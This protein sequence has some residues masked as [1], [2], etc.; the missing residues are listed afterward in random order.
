MNIVLAIAAVAVSVFSAISFYKAG[1][2]KAKATKEIL[3]G[4][5]MGW[6][7]K[8]PMGVVRVIAWLEILGAIGVV[9]A[10]IGAYLTGLVWSQWVGVAAG[11]GLALTMAVAFAM[12]AARG[13]AKYTWKMN[14]KLFLAA[15][16]ATALQAVVVLPLF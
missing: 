8:T 15:A 7:E 1:T 3:V 14:L 5:G 6:V 11:A 16:I 2:F 13:E 9:V 12:H 4:A 10:P